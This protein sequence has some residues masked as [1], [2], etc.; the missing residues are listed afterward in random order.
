M[1]LLV[2]S[3]EV[4]RTLDDILHTCQVRKNLKIV[5]W[6]SSWLHRGLHMRGWETV[7]GTRPRCAP[8]GVVAW[9]VATRRSPS[10]R[11]MRFDCSKFVKRFVNWCRGAVNDVAGR[12]TGLFR[13]PSSGE[14]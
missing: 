4:E 13:V 8:R 9:R 10:F 14:N 1:L 6:P 12:K 11:Y 3:I 7:A 5:L 2:K